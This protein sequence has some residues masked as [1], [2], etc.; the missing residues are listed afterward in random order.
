MDEAALAEALE[1]A[2]KIIA[3]GR[4]IAL[5][6]AGISVESGIPDFRSKDGLWSRYDPME[7]G[8]ISAFVADPGKVWRMIL[9][10]YELLVSAKPN[11]AHEGLARLEEMGLLTSVITQNIDGL[12][13]LAGSKEVV[14]FHGHTRTLTCLEC[15]A[16]VGSGEVELDE[17]PPRCLCGG[18]LKPDVVF[19]GE[20]IPV[21]ANMR[22]TTAAQNAGSVLVVGTSAEVAPANLLPDIAR[23]NGAGII[24]VDVMTTGLAKRAD[25]F[26]LGMA[27]E[28]MPRLLEEV[29]SIRGG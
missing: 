1:G 28:V 20:Q 12:H 13:Q 27:G 24:V 15:R 11:P 8:T 4:V 21:E 3:G 10:M 25:V 19:F 7:Y 14:E 16:S 6:G 18:A 2:A 5:T 23:A 26:L 9:E 17:L 29:E 22:A